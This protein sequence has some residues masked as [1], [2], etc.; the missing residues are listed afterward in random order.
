MDLYLYCRNITNNYTRNY[1]LGNLQ[2]CFI[3]YRDLVLNTFKTHELDLSNSP[4]FFSSSHFLLTL[5][6]SLFTHTLFFLFFIFLL[7]HIQRL[8][9]ASLGSYQLTLTTNK[10]IPKNITSYIQFDLLNMERRELFIRTD[11]MTVVCFCKLWLSQLRW[12]LYQRVI[13]ISNTPP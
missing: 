7:L 8:K 4:Q 3:F 5:F 12:Y 9:Y 2:G 11:C 6:F 1:K 10:F 13:N